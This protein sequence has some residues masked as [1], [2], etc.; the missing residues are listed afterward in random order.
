MTDLLQ[1]FFS[2]L[3]ELVDGQGE[4]LE[5]QLP[6][7]RTPVEGQFGEGIHVVA[8]GS[9]DILQGLGRDEVRQFSQGLER[10]K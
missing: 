8:K 3:L 5:R 2:R 4:T 10:E 1:M 6:D 7:G 9:L